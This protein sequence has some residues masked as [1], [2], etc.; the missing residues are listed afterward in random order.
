MEEWRA[1]PDHT[2][3]VFA[4]PDLQSRLPAWRKLF[5]MVGMR[6]VEVIPTHDNQG[7]AVQLFESP[8]GKSFDLPWPVL[9]VYA[10]G[11]AS[12]SG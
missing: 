9:I 11:M 10:P 1:D 5:R 12:S 2:S 4:L 6:T 8:D 7:E 3:T